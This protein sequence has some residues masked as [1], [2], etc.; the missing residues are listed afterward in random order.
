MLHTTRAGIVA[1][2]ADARRQLKALIVTAPEPLRDSLRGR[3]WRQQ[4]R[5]CA[6]LVALPT[7]PVEHRATVRALALTAQRALAARHD[8]EQLEAELR[9]LV[10]AVAPALLTQP[11]IGPINAAQLL[12]SWSHPG[13]FRSE[14]AFAMLAG[15]AP[16]PGVLG[17]GGPPSPQSWR[18]S[19][20]EPGLAHHRDAAPGPSRADQGLH[21]PPH[22]PGQEPA[23]DPPLPQ[24][25]RCPPA[26]PAPG[27]HRHQPSQQLS[28]KR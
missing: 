7:D 3:P 12:I 6:G 10:M 2:G 17:P 28:R 13:R 14:A 22:R 21:Q 23:R 5:A 11:G 27:A 4:L 15:A 25:H 24:A 16:V 20:A 9:Q 18:G 19:A 1:A 8:A 26:V